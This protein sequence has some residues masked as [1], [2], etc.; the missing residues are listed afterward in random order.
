M[1]SCVPSLLAQCLCRLHD[2]III[3]ATPIYTPI[4]LSLPLNKES[5]I[6]IVLAIKFP[7]LLITS[8]E[9]TAMPNR[10]SQ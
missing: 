8:L 1:L 3:L 4:L 5:V 6:S 2:I 9:I 10:V 7:P